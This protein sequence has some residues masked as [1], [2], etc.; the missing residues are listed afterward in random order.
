M[1]KKSLFDT[2]AGK[3]GAV[4]V[5]LAVGA[6]GGTVVGKNLVEATNNLLVGTEDP[7]KVQPAHIYQ[8]VNGC[9]SFGWERDSKTAPNFYDCEAGGFVPRDLM[10]LRAER[11]YGSIAR[12][13]RR[14]HCK[15]NPEKPNTGEREERFTCPGPLPF[16]FTEEPPIVFQ[17]DSALN[18]EL[19][20]AVAWPEFKRDTSIEADIGPIQPVLLACGSRLA[21]RYMTPLQLDQELQEEKDAKE[22]RSRLAKGIRLPSVQPNGIDLPLPPKPSAEDMEAVAEVL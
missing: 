16:T 7:L 10:E 19:C 11:L 12:D 20:R 5:A 14:A 9:H 13:V 2:T 4:L 1:K 21:P 18:P 22:R 3:I 17:D 8:A 15:V 6:I